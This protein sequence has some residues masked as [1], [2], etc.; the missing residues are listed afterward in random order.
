M[1]EHASTLFGNGARP[2]G[3]LKTEKKLGDEGAKAAI[4]GWNAAHEGRG[5]SGRTATLYDGWDFQPLT[6]NSVDS[7]FQQLRI[8]QL[9]EI[10]RAFNIPSVLIGE[11][12]RATW[13]NSAEMQR[14][15]LMLTLEPWLLAVEGAFRRALI[16]KDDRKRFAI[17]FE[18]DDFSKV[19]LAVLATA[20]SSLVSGRVLNPNTAR[21]WLGLPPY[22][23][24]EEYANP[25]TGASQPGTQLAL[26]AP[27]PDDEEDHDA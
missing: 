15:F 25:H 18:R 22:E 23:G 10:A 13:S 11:L 3:I 9:Q 20:I 7:Q 16:A 27:K 1:E 8:F 17:R 19:D 5:K 12:T 24:G 21:E 4:K 2:S 26:P 6:I 14:L